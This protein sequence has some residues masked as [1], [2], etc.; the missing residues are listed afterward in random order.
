MSFLVKRLF[1]IN[2]SLK[3]KRINFF[4]MRVGPLR[5]TGCLYTRLLSKT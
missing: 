4:L 5:V 3:T 2:V 1:K